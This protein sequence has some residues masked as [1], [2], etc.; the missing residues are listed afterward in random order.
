[1]G[2]L[3]PSRDAVPHGR[4]GQDVPYSPRIINSLGQQ[5]GDLGHVCRRRVRLVYVSA[6]VLERR[7]LV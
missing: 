1:V 3:V 4:R 6:E 5:R 7:P 2:P